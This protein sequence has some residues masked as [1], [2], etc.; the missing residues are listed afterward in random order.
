MQVRPETPQDYAAIARLHARAFGNRAAEAA[1]VA[2]RR[3]SAQYDPELSLVAEE[4]GVIVGHAFF[5]PCTIRLLG[6]DVRAVN[7]APLAVA[8]E[9]Q[10]QRIGS[11]LVSEG[12]ATA[13]RKNYAVSM[14]LGDPAYYSRLGYRPAAFGSAFAEVTGVPQPCC[15]LHRRAVDSADAAALNALW[16][17]EDCNVDFSIEP[18]E[19]LV[20]WLSPNPAIQAS[21]YTCAGEVVGYTRVHTAEKDSPRAFF[22]RDARAAA[23]IAHALAQNAGTAKL[24]LP[25]HPYSRSAQAFPATCTAWEAGMARS[26]APS[27]FDEYYAKVKEGCRIPGRPIWP[28]CFDVA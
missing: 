14:V 8:P 17:I 26:L 27:P 15:G 13:A 4:G 10:R 20:E 3:Q 12:H 24:L 23:S 22:A 5:L 16:R 25:L 28:V 18:G 9:R 21:V 1:V 2:L 11:A 7:L 19:D 6:E